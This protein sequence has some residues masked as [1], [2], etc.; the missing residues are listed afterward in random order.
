MFI[1]APELASHPNIRHAFFTRQ[2]G[3]SEGI[4]ASLNGGL[5]SSDDPAR[6]RE[7]RRLMA[8][9]MGVR[10]DALVSVHQ[11]HSPDAVRV[12]APWPGERPKADGMATNVAKIALA[13]TTADCGPILFADPK[14]GI[15]GAA[16]AGWRGAL[17]GVLE[18][19][20]AAME[21]IGAR[22]SRI[23]A[24][25]GPTISQAA[26]EVGP[27]MKAKFIEFG[28]GGE[29]LLPPLRQARTRDVRS[30]RLHPRA[31][32][33]GAHR[34]VRGS[35]SVHLLRRGALLQLSAHDPRLGTRLWP[36]DLGN[37]AHSLRPATSG[38]SHARCWPPSTAII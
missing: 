25:L 37:R 3:V 6:V 12:D 28:F 7:N 31:A 38:V 11:I 18:S 19:T 15:I 5:G 34:R 14:G 36:A 23:V 8:E 10:T 9:T 29:A 35:W 22:R 24:V 20:I 33:G 4:Y 16:H 32:R 17:T 30:A 13:I 1:E 21:R 2:G 26:Y 27:E